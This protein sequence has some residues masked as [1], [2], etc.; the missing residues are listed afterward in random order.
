MNRWVRI[1]TIT[2]NL[3]NNTQAKF[4]TW[5]DLDRSDNWRKVTEYIDGGGWSVHE[6]SAFNSFMSFMR[7]NH[8]TLI[9]KDRDT[10]LEIKA[11]E[12][13]T[14]AGNFVSWR[15]D[16]ATYDF[17]NLSAREIDATQPLY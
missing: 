15:S 17:R 14:W 16:G 12:P 4:E 2:Y 8:P 7:A 9:P 13:I 5:I 10:G 6:V 11:D 1:K 3:A